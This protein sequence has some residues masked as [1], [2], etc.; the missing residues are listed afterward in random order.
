MSQ[1]GDELSIPDFSESGRL[2][3]IRV[4][5]PN[6]YDHNAPLRLFRDVNKTVQ[7]A[8]GKGKLIV[9]KRAFPKKSMGESDFEVNLRTGENLDLY[10]AHHEEVRLRLTAM[11]RTLERLNQEMNYCMYEMHKFKRAD[12]D[13]ES[14]LSMSCYE[15]DADDD[16][17]EH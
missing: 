3:P 12:L 14:D 9:N 8:R 5:S 15:D 11:K 7:P 4:D 6:D 1:D 13:A 10:R 2:T 16:D 17:S